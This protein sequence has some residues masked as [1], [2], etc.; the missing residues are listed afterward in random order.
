MSIA[1]LSSDKTDG[2]WFKAL[3]DLA[4]D[5]AIEQWPNIDDAKRVEFA[6][7]WQHQPGTLLPM[8][9]L[10][11]ICSMGAGI[12]HLLNDQQLP[13]GLPV[14]RLIDPLLCSSMFEYLLS[15][16]MQQLRHW[17]HYRQQQRQESWTPRLTASIEQTKVGILGLGELGSYSAKRLAAIGFQLS[18][19][20]QSQKEIPGVA[21]YRGDA[22]LSAFIGEQDFIIC[23]LPL[24]AKTDGIL[25]H[26]LF[27]QMKAGSYLINVGRGGHVVEKD[28]LAALASGQLAGACLDVFQQEPLPSG[29]PF[30]RC[31]NLALTPHCSSITDPVSVAPQIIENYRRMQEGRP[32]VNEVDMKR[33]Y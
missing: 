21:S 3:T 12:D 2:S 27:Q 10:R 15:A 18:G 17:S 29:H 6:L 19:W 1:I 14:V 30:W 28:L 22:E 9:N 13:Q 5:I 26:S 31:D 7:C 32:L 11:C 20:S 24:T 16:I 23:L 25:N 8:V 4:P 33:G